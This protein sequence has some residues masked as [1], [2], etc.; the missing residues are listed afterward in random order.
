MKF[1]F[2]VALP[3]L[4][5]VDIVLARHATYFPFISKFCP[6]LPPTPCTCHSTDYMVAPENRNFFEHAVEAL[7][8]GCTLATARDNDELDDMVTE[9]LMYMEPAGVNI[10]YIGLIRKTFN[11]LD[12]LP[13]GTT[14]PANDPTEGEPI[15]PWMWID[16]CTDYVFNP[17]FGDEPKNAGAA[18][19]RVGAMTLQQGAVLDVGVSNRIP[20]LY[21]CCRDDENP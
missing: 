9:A 18:D 8:M 13:G 21:K 17:F 1:L 15:G 11:E 2:A 4:G 5:L 3:F 19:E 6:R 16:G 10:I 20:A 12:D 14:V 7:V